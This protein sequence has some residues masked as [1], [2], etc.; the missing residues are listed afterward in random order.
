MSLSDSVEDKEDWI[1]LRDE[2]I[3]KKNDLSEE[4]RDLFEK[5]L[6]SWASHGKKEMA[7]KPGISAKD[8]KRMDGI[9]EEMFPDQEIGFSDVRKIF[10]VFYH[11]MY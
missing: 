7:A 2:I 5:C 8:K 6:S 3:E 1:D 4:D 9:I 11:E 10:R